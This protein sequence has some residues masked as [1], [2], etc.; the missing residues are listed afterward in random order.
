MFIRLEN[1]NN[2]T[3]LVNVNH[4]IKIIE[5]DDYTL[6]TLTGDLKIKTLM[7]MDSLENLIGI[8]LKNKH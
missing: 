4:I 1:A 3:Q 7:K 2:K 6:V 8:S 5:N